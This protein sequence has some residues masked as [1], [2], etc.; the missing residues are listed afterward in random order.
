MFGQRLKGIKAAIVIVHMLAPMFARTVLTQLTGPAGMA[1]CF[2]KPYRRT[3]PL[4]RLVRH[5]PRR[6]D[7]RRGFPF[8]PRGRSQLAGVTPP[9]QGEAPRGQIPRLGVKAADGA[10]AR[11]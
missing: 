10:G 3:G 2:G 1:T 11:R 4:R 5:S 7:S 6:L 8:R 9:G